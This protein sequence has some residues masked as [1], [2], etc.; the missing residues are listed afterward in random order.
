MYDIYKYVMKIANEG[1]IAWSEAPI[2][3]VDYTKPPFLCI[4]IQ[5]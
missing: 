1:V 3:H 4:Y 2:P 5:I